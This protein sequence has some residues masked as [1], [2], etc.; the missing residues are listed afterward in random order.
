MAR[1]EYQSYSLLQT[2]KI[3]GLALQ[4]SEAAA[5]WKYGVSQS[6]PRGKTFTAIA[7]GTR[8]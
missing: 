4:N 1:G 5:S 6:G 7:T 2:D 8:Y 3:V